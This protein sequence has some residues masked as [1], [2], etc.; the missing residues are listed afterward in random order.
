CS[1]SVLDHAESHCSIVHNS[2]MLLN[3]SSPRNGPS[4]HGCDLSC[5]PAIPASRRNAATGVQLLTVV[6]AKAKAAAARIPSRI[7]HR[8][9]QPQNEPHRRPYRGGSG[10]GKVKVLLILSS[11][12][13]K[14]FESSARFS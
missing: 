1:S 5:V 6:L 7:G 9:S 2:G 8:L 13:S 11:S 12:C 3:R 10:R 14:T 4:T